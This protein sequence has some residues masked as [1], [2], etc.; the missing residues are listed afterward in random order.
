MNK[1]SESEKNYLFVLHTLE[2]IAKPAKMKMVN[3]DKEKIVLHQ[4][5]FL[6]ESEECN[7]IFEKIP[8]GSSSNKQAARKKNPIFHRAAEPLL[9]IAFIVRRYVFRFSKKSCRTE[10]SLMFVFFILGSV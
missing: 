4:F 2:T 9:I 6:F 10:E 7:K 1:R 8:T 5:F 3:G